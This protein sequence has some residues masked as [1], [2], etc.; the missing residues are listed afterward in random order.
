MSVVP[1]VTDGPAKRVRHRDDR[2]RDRSQCDERDDQQ[3]GER[4]QPEPRERE[5]NDRRDD[6]ERR[7][8]IEVPHHDASSLIGVGASVTL[9]ESRPGTALASADAPG[10]V[11]SRAAHARGRS[12]PITRLTTMTDDYAGPRRLTGRRPSWLREV[13]SSFRNTLR[14]WYW[15]VR[16][17]MK[18]CSPISGLESP[19]R[20]SLAISPS[21]NVRRSRVSSVRLRAVSPVA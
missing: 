1:T 12:V 15:T 13:M 5:K 6:D 16:G 18:S 10:L 14:R 20:A 19:S 2:R 3:R 8:R 4:E 21:W 7:P 17:L 11:A 9:R